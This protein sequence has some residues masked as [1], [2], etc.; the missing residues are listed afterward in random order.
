MAKW[1][2]RQGRGIIAHIQQTIRDK[3]DYNVCMYGSVLY[4]GMSNNDL[5]IQ[6]I[7]SG[8]TDKHDQHTLIAKD[9]AE[10]LNGKIVGHLDLNSVA[11]QCYM[12]EFGNAE[13][14]MR[15]IDMVI[16][17]VL[18]YRPSDEEILKAAERIREKEEILKRLGC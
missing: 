6:L 16:R 13:L 9:V 7:P 14:G 15:R 10:C 17:R 5:D 12:I 11:E 1:T 3:W 8:S 4:K 18:P 2:F